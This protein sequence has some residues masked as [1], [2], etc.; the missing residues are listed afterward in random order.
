M[1]L[2]PSARKVPARGT[3]LLYGVMLRGAA[4]VEAG[5]E[6]TDLEEQMVSL[7]RVVA[8]EEEVREFGRVFREE[9]ALGASSLFPAALSQRGLEEGYALADLAGDLPGVREER[10]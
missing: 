1:G 2:R 9:Q 7:L 3:G 8:S 5:L 6:L 10:R 4:R